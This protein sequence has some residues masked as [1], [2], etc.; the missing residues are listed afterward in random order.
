MESFRPG[1]ISYCPFE[2]KGGLDGTEGIDRPL[3]EAR[4]AAEEGPE[5]GPDGLSD[6]DRTAPGE[7]ALPSQHTPTP[8]SSPNV[9]PE[10]ENRRRLYLNVGRPRP[11]YRVIPNVS[12]SVSQGVSSDSESPTPSTGRVQHMKPKVRL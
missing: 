11:F 10:E 7:Q 4:D 9:S 1:S 5:G 2:N 6:A 3:E 8:I 12:T